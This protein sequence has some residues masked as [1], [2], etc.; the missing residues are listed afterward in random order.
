V[1]RPTSGAR[2]LANPWDVNVDWNPSARVNV[3]AYVGY[4]VGKEVMKRIYPAGS[5]GSFGYLEVTHK[6]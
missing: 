6:F 4:S 1:G 2:S 3:N 5:N